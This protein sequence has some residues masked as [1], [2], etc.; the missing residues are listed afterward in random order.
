[1][2]RETIKD[3]PDFENGKPVRVPPFDV[4]LTAP[5]HGWIDLGLW[6]TGIAYGISLSF[7]FDPFVAIRQFL[8]GVAQGTGAV[9]LIHDE[10]H[11]HFIRAG[12][13]SDAGLF[14]LAVWNTFRLQSTGGDASA[15]TLA[16]DVMT[17]RDAFARSFYQAIIEIWG[18]PDDLTFRRAWFNFDENEDPYE[19]EHGLARTLPEVRSPALDQF[20]G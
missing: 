19:D 16:F 5:E 7:V 14:R 6:T 12:E 4:S 9:L 20:L 17:E 1:M 15:L 13:T 8:E 18:L 10:G 3:Y 2:E 11:D